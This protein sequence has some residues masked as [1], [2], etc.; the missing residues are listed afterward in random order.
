MEGASLGDRV[1]GKRNS[2]T[3]D[4]QSPIQCIQGGGCGGVLQ[5]AVA[6]SAPR[7]RCWSCHREFLGRGNY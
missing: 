5:W 2:L 4:F 3:G 1:K 6:A 7:A